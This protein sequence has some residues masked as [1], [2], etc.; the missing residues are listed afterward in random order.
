MPGHAGGSPY[1]IGIES[2]I[3]W[4]CV[5]DRHCASAF[6][7]NTSYIWQ[8][9]FA[10]KYMFQGES[11]IPDAEESCTTRW[12]LWSWS[13]CTTLFQRLT[14]TFPIHQKHLKVP[15]F[16]N[17]RELY[18]QFFL[19]P[20]YQPIWCKLHP[21]LLPQLH[22]TIK[23]GTT[24]AESCLSQRGGLGIQCLL[25]TLVIINWMQLSHIEP[26]SPM[27]SGH[28]QSWKQ[29]LDMKHHTLECNTR[30][31]SRDFLKTS[32]LEGHAMLVGFK[33]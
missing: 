11:Q 17:K 7:Q 26:L 15:D 6:I 20:S 16:L 2:K 25:S 23:F 10:T 9:I 3:G 19:D 22:V 33:V 14:T 5:T 28:Q 27:T 8:F 1:H 32:S 30:L 21:S 31:M 29:F 4:G 24:C 18:R 12:F 13:A